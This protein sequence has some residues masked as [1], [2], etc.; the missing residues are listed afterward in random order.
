MGGYYPRLGGYHASLN[1]MSILIM[2]H[3]IIHRRAICVISD[4]RFILT[5]AFK[6]QLT[7][8]CNGECNID[9]NLEQTNIEQKPEYAAK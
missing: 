3:N 2:G 5:I 7:Q 4:N 9:E 1:L 8:P 6:Y